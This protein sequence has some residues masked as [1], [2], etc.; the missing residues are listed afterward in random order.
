VYHSQISILQIA[1]YYINE[2]KFHKL[3]GLNYQ[4]GVSY[5][6]YTESITCHI[7]QVQSFPIKIVWLRYHI[8]ELDLKTKM[9]NYFQNLGDAFG[10]L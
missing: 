8:L 2:V 5:E 7:K 10:L 6:S 3:K 4:I 1:I 9:K